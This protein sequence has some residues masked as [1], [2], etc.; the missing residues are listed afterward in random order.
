[1]LP[2]CAA[3]SHFARRFSGLR[4]P[5]PVLR[6]QLSVPRGK[7]PVCAGF[8]HFARAIIRPKRRVIRFARLL[9]GENIGDS[10]GL[11]MAE[12]RAPHLSKNAGR[13]REGEI[14]SQA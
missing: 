12:R 5:T 11:T 7:N 13:K 6:G 1:M 8:F 3:I 9:N 10:G 2:V 4:G 14:Q